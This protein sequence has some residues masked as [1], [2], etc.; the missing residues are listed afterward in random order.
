[1]CM[2]KLQWKEPSRVEILKGGLGVEWDWTE[3]KSL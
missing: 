1:M 2:T 3:L